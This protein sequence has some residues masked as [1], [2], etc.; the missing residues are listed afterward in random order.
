VD[1]YNATWNNANYIGITTLAIPNTLGWLSFNS[2]SLFQT[3]VSGAEP[4]Y[5]L[6][7][8]G[9]EDHGRWEQLILLSSNAESRRMSISVHTA[10]LYTLASL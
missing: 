3:W 10:A 9:N 8:T 6:I 2:T 1:E 4:N 7:I 5:G